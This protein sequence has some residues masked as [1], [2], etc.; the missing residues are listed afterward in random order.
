MIRTWDTGSQLSH[1]CYCVYNSK[2]KMFFS[3]FFLMLSKKSGLDWNSLTWG[4]HPTWDVWKAIID[5]AGEEIL[6][7]TPHFMFC[8]QVPPKFKLNW[9]LLFRPFG[10]K[11]RTPDWWERSNI[12][13][14]CSNHFNY[15]LGGYSSSYLLLLNPSILFLITHVFRLINL[16]VPRLILNLI[17]YLL[18]SQLNPGKNSI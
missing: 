15:H 8:H 4:T 9:S 12:Y 1:V 7:P 17:A 3:L 6:D 11:Y 10:P 16:R 2:T 18:E 14:S 5:L 13:V